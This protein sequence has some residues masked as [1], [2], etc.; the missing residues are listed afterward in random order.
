MNKQTSFLIEE[1]DKTFFEAPK[2]IFSEQKILFQNLKVSMEEVLPDYKEEE[3]TGN[4]Q[5]KK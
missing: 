2:S 1:A 3:G 4:H 5:V